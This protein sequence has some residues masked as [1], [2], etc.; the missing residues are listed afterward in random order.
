MD[1]L[2]AM[3]TFVRV[4]DTG[5]FSA[6]AR[7]LRVGQPAVSKAV[8]QLEDRLGVKLLT[9]S[10][11]GL[12]T[13]EAGQ[14]F[15]ERA[16]RAIEEADEADLAA[17][18][19]GTGLTGR[20]RVCAAV[21]FARI[22]V[23]PQLPKFLAEHPGL[24]LEV[25]LDDRPIDLVQESI[26][27]GLRMGGLAD[28]SLTARRIG[29]A[30]RL[31]VGTPAYFARVGLPVVPGDLAGHEAIVYLPECD[32]AAWSFRQ[33]SSEL[34]V[35][36]RSRLRITAAEGV[37]AAVLAD[38]GVAMIS[39]WMFSPELA[40]GAAQAVLTDWELPSVS[41]W[42]VYPTGR[43]ATAKARAFVSFLERTLPK[44]ADA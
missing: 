4:V 13:T 27:V 7:Q 44:L 32:S 3:E 9:R 42:A 30:R 11:R 29:R 39:E 12:S 33:G 41:L 8:A 10:T 21:T 1:R 20:L 15:Y 23:V 16:R 43:I 22:H 24:E 28:S 17:R 6:A 26:D 31:V 2:V 38:M 35:T 37:R 14:S 36:I 19:A 25:I 5:S 34:S 18:G 40:T